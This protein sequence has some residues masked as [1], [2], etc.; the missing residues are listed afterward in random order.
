VNT[1]GWPTGLLISA[2]LT[3]L[4][5]AIYALGG[6]EWL[7]LRAYDLRFAVRGPRP[8]S[9][10][11]V[12]VTLDEESLQKL[13]TTLREFKRSLLA[14]AIERLASSG[15]RLIGIDMVLSN[16]SS[17][18]DDDHQLRDAI[19][20]AG[21][22]VLPRFISSEMTI[23]PWAVF[24]D[25]EMGEGLINVVLDEDG[26]LRSMPVLSAEVI[27]EELVPYLTFSL[28]IARLL[29][30]PEGVQELDLSRPDQIRIGSLNIPSPDNKLLINFYGPPGTFL[31]LP[32]WR[33][34]SGEFPSDWVSEKM[35]LIGSYTP[36]G[37]DVYRTP[38]TG[39]V[40]RVLAPWGGRADL[41]HLDRM[42]G[43]E[44]HANALQTVL[45]KSFIRRS[46][47]GVVWA[48]VV[49]LGLV[50]AAI[51][52]LVQRLLWA[53]ILFGLWIVLIP[54]ASMILFTLNN[55]WMD[56]VPLI[57]TVAVN[58][59]G[60]VAYQRY[61]EGK[62]KRRI[63]NL[64][65]RYVSTQVVA[66]LIQ[67]PSLLHLGGTK[68]RL[69][70]LFSD[71]RGFT[72]MSEQ[73]DPA[74]VSRLLNEYF[75]EMTALIFKYDGTLDKFIGDA[76]LVFF[77]DPIPY[78][79]HARRAVEM[80]LEMQEAVKRLNQKW[81][82][83]GGRPITVGIG[84]NTGTVI[85]GNMGSEEYVDYTVIGDEVNLACRLEENAKG[86]QILITQNTYAEIKGEVK[87]RPLEA[88][89]VKG[90]SQPIPV[91]EVLGLNSTRPLR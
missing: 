26:V 1:K 3:L 11:V 8:V 44:I 42:Y 31:H 33:V 45:D 25:V 71:I 55:F 56:V 39:G 48:L 6:W 59:F 36:S 38:F 74:E 14:R 29:N 28:E 54:I 2:T 41:V 87:A 32:I 37:Y 65:G 17:H 81:L 4:M 19:A 10:Q 85:V 53:T 21:N 47:P 77:G 75:K 86:G 83:E 34:V 5:G 58:Y 52:L 67:T 24:R 68:K 70:I 40:Q 7:E 23:P 66:R 27:Q 69:T 16:P 84:I 51:L 88:L 89:S 18:P 20:R 57:A 76:I 43:V 79:D 15:A 63:T 73:M 13:G 90:K 46:T 50:S 72:A 22:V 64:F 80:A 91:Y 12:L 62:E 61:V 9:N 30:D 35:V 78:T 82:G 49:L 60:G